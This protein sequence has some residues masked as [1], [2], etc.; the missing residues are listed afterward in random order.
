VKSEKITA[1]FSHARRRMMQ[2]FANLPEPR[3]SREVS[4]LWSR[5]HDSLRGARGIFAVC[6]RNAP[7]HNIPGNRNFGGKGFLRCWMEGERF[8]LIQN[9]ANSRDFRY[10]SPIFSDTN[11]LSYCETFDSGR[12]LGNVT[13]AF[14]EAVTFLLPIAHSVN[15]WPYIIENFDATD[16]ERVLA[17]LKAFARFKLSTAKGF[18]EHR[19]FDGD[20]GEA[21]RIAEECIRAMKSNEMAMLYSHIRERFLWVRIILLKAIIQTLSNPRMSL[22]DLFYNL[23]KFLHDELAR[24]PGFETYVAFRFFSLN[25]KEHFFSPVQKNS[26]KLDA[27]LRSMS[28]DLSHWR[29]LYEMLTMN[30]AKSGL[31]FPFP[32]FLT[33]DRRF[34]TLSELFHLQG[35]IY[36]G[37]GTR[38]DVLYSKALLWPVSRQLASSCAEFYT[39]EAVA[40]RKYRSEKECC[41]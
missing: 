35:L 12:G 3:T 33:F 21:T 29:S 40:S 32:H 13:D 28:W 18:A 5:Y 14:R 1:A 7:L 38:C 36:Y 37:E 30:S 34:V 26:R 4:E 24:I 39:P 10:G 17:S 11:F 20:E 31:P 8:F 27:M 19:T 6:D 25:T 2:D 41:R 22:D 15:A 16:R 23:L 9:K